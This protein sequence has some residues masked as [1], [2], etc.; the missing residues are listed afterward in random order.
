MVLLPVG[1]PSHFVFLHFILTRKPAGEH[2]CE[3]L[4]SD[5]RI[6]EQLNDDNISMATFN[7]K[8]LSTTS[9]HANFSDVEKFDSICIITAAD[10]EMVIKNEIFICFKMKKLKF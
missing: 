10:M 1:L 5:I 2:S 6:C 3:S 9:T 7:W 4:A 8:Q